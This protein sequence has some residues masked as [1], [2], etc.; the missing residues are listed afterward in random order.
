[1]AAL[2]A[3][4]AL[5]SSQATASAYRVAVVTNSHRSAAARSCRESIR[6]SSSIESMS[7]ASSNAMPAGSESVVTMRRARDPS[8]SRSVRTSSGSTA[9]ERNQS[10]SS[11]LQIRVGAVVVG[12]RTPARVTTSPSREFTIVD[13]PAPVDPPTTTS[14]GASRRRALG[15]R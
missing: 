8:V 5:R 12:R 9:P 7:G 11:R 15:R 13:F 14:S 10:R 2:R 4:A 3:A 1:M 6:L